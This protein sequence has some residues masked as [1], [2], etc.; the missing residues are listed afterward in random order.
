M[1]E[2]LFKEI[3]KF[4]PMGKSQAGKLPD[5]VSSVMAR[6]KARSYA[7][8]QFSVKENG[9]FLKD[10]ERRQAFVDRYAWAVPSENTIKEIS[11]FVKNDKVLEIG[12][13]LGLWAKL[14]SEYGI[15]IKATDNFDKH[16]KV[17][18]DSFFPVRKMTYSSAFKKYKNRDVLFLCWPPYKSS[19]A[20]HSLSKFN[21]TKLIYIGEAEGGCNADD[22]FFRLLKTQWEKSKVVDITQ[23]PLIHDRMWFYVRK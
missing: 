11:E 23:W 17:N 10:F 5:D 19:M 16:W 21:G 1:S 13:G 15:N 3:R 9:I 12:A 4:G 8:I 6:V 7:K 20:H 14:I 18:Y 22:P 2:K